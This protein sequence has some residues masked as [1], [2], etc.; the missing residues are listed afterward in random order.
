[1][2]WQNLN[3]R[4]CR[5]GPAKSI[6]Q[7]EISVDEEAPLMKD[8]SI[9]DGDHVATRERETDALLERGFP[10]FSSSRFQPSSLPPTSV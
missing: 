3:I 10:G 8:G 7:S 5:R 1:M 4:L 6:E 2:V 9:Q